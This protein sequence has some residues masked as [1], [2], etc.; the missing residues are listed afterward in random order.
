MCLLNVRSVKKNTLLRIVSF[1]TER[2]LF[3]YKTSTW[4]RK[5]WV[6][7]IRCHVEFLNTSEFLIIYSKFNFGVLIS[8]LENNWI[9]C[10]INIFLL[11]VYNYFCFAM[12]KYYFFSSDYYWFFL[13]LKGCFPILNTIF[14]R[15]NF[16]IHP[17]MQWVE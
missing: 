13:I 16:Q 10:Y 7:Q 8:R 5:N 1:F 15:L 11:W 9:K 12:E 17:T 2:T 4:N 6:S 3:S 14:I